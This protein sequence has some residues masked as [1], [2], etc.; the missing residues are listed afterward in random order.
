MR[1]G[2]R[3]LLNTTAGVTFRELGWRGEFRIVAP[4]AVMAELKPKIEDMVADYLSRD[5]W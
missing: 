2:L 4:P 5:A 3:A 1:E